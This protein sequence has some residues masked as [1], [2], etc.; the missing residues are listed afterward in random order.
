MYGY[1]TKLL[2]S[3]T[4]EESPI[5]ISDWIFQRTRWMKGTLQT[6]IV[7]LKTSFFV[8]NQMRLRHHCSIILFLIFGTYSFYVLP[9]ILLS[10]FLHKNEFFYTIW[11][12]NLSISVIYIYSAAFHS[13]IRTSKTISPLNIIAFAL[14]PFYFILHTIASY[15]AIV[16]LILKPFHWN[17]TKH[18]LTKL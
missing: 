16:Q 17:K 2:D 14:F 9:L 18:G 8:P 12:Y 5:Y 15:L 3:Y 13:L 1:K 10:A 6:I 4:L 7:Y 11:Q